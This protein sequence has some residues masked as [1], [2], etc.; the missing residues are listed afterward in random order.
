MKVGHLE[1]ET[2]V[3]ECHSLEHTAFLEYDEEENEIYLSVHLCRQEWYR[4]IWYALKYVFGFRSSYGD[5]D[6]FIWGKETCARILPYI[7]KV[8]EGSKAET[9]IDNIAS[10]D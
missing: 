8:A 10:A 4:R 3:C 2:L 9:L 1:M 6:G 7:K 5:F